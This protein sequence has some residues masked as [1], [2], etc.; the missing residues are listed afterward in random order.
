MVMLQVHGVPER[1]TATKNI[2]LQASPRYYSNDAKH[3]PRHNKERVGTFQSH[4]HRCTCSMR[5][6]HEAVGIVV[7]GQRFGNRASPGHPPV[8][9]HPA[10]LRTV[11]LLY[12]EGRPN[13]ALKSA[14]SVAR[15]EIEEKHE[16]AVSR[17]CVT[18][19]HETLPVK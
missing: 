2:L 6:Q 16:P 15:A 19:I 4:V 8:H 10:A 13:P 5:D 1:L 17:R 11:A 7:P 3:E 12:G 18:T 14:Q 9:N